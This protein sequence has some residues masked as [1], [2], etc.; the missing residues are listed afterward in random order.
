MEF[1]RGKLQKLWNSSGLE[2]KIVSF[3]RGKTLILRNSS[4]V[5]KD[6][7]EFLEKKVPFQEFVQG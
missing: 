5:N 2:S 4:G 6:F 1:F 3:Y 7:M